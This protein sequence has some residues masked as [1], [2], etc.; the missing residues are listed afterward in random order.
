[1]GL[2]EPAISEVVSN[3]QAIPSTAAPEDY[4]PLFRNPDL[5]TIVGRYW[6]VRLD[7]GEPRIFETD[8]GVQVLARCHWRHPQAAVA[9]LVH[10]LEGSCDSTYMRWM[11]QAAL[12]AGLDVIRLNVRNCGGTEHLAPTLYHSGLTADLRSVIEQLAP[13]QTFA[14]GFSMGGNQALKLAGEWG[15]QFPSHVAGVCSV[16]APIDL[17]ACARRLGEPRNRIYERH[18]LSSLTAR[19]RRKAALFPRSFSLEALP[20]IRSIIDFDEY[21]TAPGFG[22]QGAAD[23]YQQSSAAG[24]LGRICLPALCIQAQDDPFIPFESVRLPD[25]PQMHFLTPKHGGHVAFL[26][27]GRVRF[28]AAQQVIRFIQDHS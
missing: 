9:L 13:R 20:R 17:A 23:Y 25:T 21:I 4:A 28:W 11:A 8:A 27:R 14:V 10:G 5:N 15:A 1:V 6:S 2:N 12:E 18:F 16:S 24:Y 22:F 3:S 19:Y 7:P 26:A